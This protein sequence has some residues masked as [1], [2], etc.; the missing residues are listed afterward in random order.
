GWSPEAALVQGSDG[1]LYGITAGN[2]VNEANGGGT[3]FKLNTNGTAF[4]T[5]YSFTATST[6][7]ATN[8][9][10]A[11]PLA[12]LIQLADG[13]FYGTACQGGNAAGT[14]FNLNADGSN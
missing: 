1:E 10:G 9:D 8:V 3:V 2:S 4:T 7:Q 5:L 13:A 6:P 14:V 12:S 11:M